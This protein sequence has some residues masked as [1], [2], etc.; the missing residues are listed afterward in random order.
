MVNN[1]QAQATLM[2]EGSR[3]LVRLAGAAAI[4]AGQR[5]EISIS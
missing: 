4:E 3:L 5:I 1:R 2:A